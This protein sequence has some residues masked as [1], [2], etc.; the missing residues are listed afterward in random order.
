VHP[1]G[2]GSRVSDEAL[3][4]SF[5]PC[6]DYAGIAVAAAGGRVW[7]GKAE[8]VGDL[9]RLLGEAIGMVEAG[10]GAVLDCVLDAPMGVAERNTEGKAVGQEAVNGEVEDK[11]DDVLE[12]GAEE[13][14]GGKAVLV[15]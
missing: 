5:R 7:G 11:G 12:E 4:I 9:E 2:M 10:V 15:G 1:E 6:P 13:R 8:G 3:G 14:G